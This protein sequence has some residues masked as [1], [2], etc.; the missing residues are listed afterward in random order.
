MNRLKLYTSSFA[1]WLTG[2]SMAIRS[3]LSSLGIK[4]TYN[5]IMTS[6]YVQHVFVIDKVPVYFAKNLTDLVRKGRAEDFPEVHT[7]IQ[8]MSEPVRPE[9]HKNTFL[10]L[11]SNA[12]REYE[13]F[14]AAFDAAS[15]DERIRYN[16][17]ES[18]LENRKARYDSFKYVYDHI[19]ADK[20]Q[21]YFFDVTITV[22]AYSDNIKQL[23]KFSENFMNF[24]KGHGVEMYLLRGKLN[25]YLRN[26]GVAAYKHA[27]DFTLPTNLMSDE[28]LAS[29]SPVYSTGLVGGK[30]VLM[31]LDYKSG[32]P[33]IVDFFKTSAA[34][35][36][37]VVS[38]AGH[39][40]TATSMSLVASLASKGVSTD[41]V[42]FK[43]NEWDKI[44]AYIKPLVISLDG[45]RPKYVSTLRL[46]D[47]EVDPEDAEFIYSMAVKSTVR[48]FA[49][50]SA[51]TEVD[52]VSLVDLESVVEIAVKKV[53]SSISG[54][55]PSNPATFYLT[56][57]LKDY[58]VLDALSN[59]GTSANS[60]TDNIKKVLIPLIL[61]RCEKYFGKTAGGENGMFGSEIKLSE[62]LDSTVT[63]YSLNKN[64]DAEMT[65]LDH[66][67]VFMT[68]TLTRKKQYLRAKQKLHSAYLVEEF[69]R[70]TE[71]AKTSAGYHG[72]ASPQLLSDISN[73]VTGSRSDNVTNILLMNSMSAFDN[74]AT[75]PIESNV[76]SVIAGK[77]SDTDIK[78]LVERFGAGIIESDMRAISSGDPKYKNAFAIKFDNGDSVI[79]TI[80]KAYIPANIERKLRQRDVVDVAI[81][82]IEE[83]EI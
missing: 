79:S 74:E 43:G 33:L 29:I 80:Y 63:V 75:R 59:L 56:E 73:S 62:V 50:A 10:S 70:V 12:R 41:V 40:K 51:I 78:I 82:E 8:Y 48:K 39:G 6:K 17:K 15:P 20:G 53:Y 24:M 21:G 45:P 1:D 13:E 26:Y 83:E 34:Q 11:M 46:D 47:L 22:H 64:T 58:M 38:K 14:K 4:L 57:N 76:T 44:D 81:K 71:E 68:R 55:N 7:M 42:D 77:L 36:I 52:E 31:G 25:K 60:L 66:I 19:T 16:L 3:R 72:S 35:V 49:I 9:I 27:G 5:K 69:V 37:I 67:K 2:G 23:E 61:L 30:G 54:F 65:T 32:L 28:N 18:Y